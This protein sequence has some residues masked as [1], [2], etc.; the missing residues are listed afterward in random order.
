MVV[1]DELSFLTQHLP[2]AGSRLIELG[3]GPARLIRQLLQRE[4]ACEAVALEVDAVQMAKN[5]QLPQERL[6]FVSAGAQAIPLLSEQFDGALMLKSLHHVP[7]PDMDAALREVARVL[8]PGGWLYVSEP[9]YGGPLNEIVRLFN[10]EGEV[11]AA[12]QQALD[13]AVAGA[14][15]RAEAEWR[16]DMPVHWPDFAQ[17]EQRMMRPSFADHALTPALI[18][19]VRAAFEPHMGPEGVHLMRPMHVRLL[20][21]SPA[22]AALR[23]GC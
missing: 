4:A 11:R 3:C 16:F 15:W 8:K 23:A 7:M 19:R 1:T 20:R 2:V 21:R 5:R 10:D 13:R 18:G 22:S 17:F 6:H 14:D 12:A 9:V